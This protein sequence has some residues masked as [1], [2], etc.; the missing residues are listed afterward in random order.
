MAFTGEA[1]GLLLQATPNTATEII[2]TTSDNRGLRKGVIKPPFRK[3]GLVG[4]Q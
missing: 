2:A 3:Y 1:A 4:H